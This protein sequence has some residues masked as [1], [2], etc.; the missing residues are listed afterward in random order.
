[1]T[2]AQDSSIQVSVDVGY[3]PKDIIITIIII[4]PL[5][6]TRFVPQCLTFEQ[7]IDRYPWVSG[8]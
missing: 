1:M 7:S 8:E 4:K 5:I 3:P 6:H 2:M